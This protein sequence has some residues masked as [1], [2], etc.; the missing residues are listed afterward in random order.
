MGFFAKLAAKPRSMKTLRLLTALALVLVATTSNRAL[1]Q[2]TETLDLIT[3]LGASE[4][5]EASILLSGNLSS[6]SV[7]LNYTG[8][9]TSWPADMMVYIFAPDGSCVVWGGYNVD[10]VGGCTDLGTGF[11]NSLWPDDWDSTP[12]GNYT[13]TLDVSA[14]AL[15]G[16]GDW[17]VEVQNAWAA[18]NTVTY[19]LEFTFDGP[20]AG[21][22]PDPLACNYVPEDQQTNPLLDVCLYAEDLFGDGYD[23]DGVCLN[24]EDGD[25]I[26]D[27]DDDCF[28]VYDEC[29]N[30]AGTSTSGCMDE[31]SCNYDPDASC[32]DGG[33]L[34]LDACGDCGG[35]GVIGCIDNTACNFD[36]NATCD[37]GGCL[38]FDEC[39]VCGGSGYFGCTDDTA[40]NYD[41]GAGC[42]DG[43]CLYS[44]ALGVCG[45]SCAADE[46]GDGL[47][48]ACF[49]PETFWL[50]VETVMEHV[51]GELDGM[52]TY[53]VNL[54]C[55]TISD[56]LYSV[57]GS[58]LSPL[59]L[60]STSGTWWNHPS[61]PSWN[62]SGLDLALLDEEPLLIYD[63]YLT[64]G[65]EHSEQGPFPGA[66]WS[67]GD[68]RP[69]FE[70]GEGNNVLV[71][72]GSGG[73]HY[74]IYP[75]IGQLNTHPGFAGDDF[76]ILV[77]QMTT[78]GDIH[79]QMNVQ[80]Y[81]SG[82]ASSAVTLLLEYDSES[83]CYDL[84]PCVGEYDECGV[85]AGPGAVYE[86]GCSGP[87]EGYCDCEG[88][89]ADA[90]GVCGGTCEADVD[91]DGVCDT[92]EIPGCDDAEACNYDEGATDNDGSCE[93]AAQYYDCAGVCLEDTDM[94]GVC[95]ELE[96]AGCLDEMACNYNPMATDDSGMCTYP[97]EYLDCNGD[98]M[99][100]VNENDIC[101]ELEA[102]GCTD[103]LACNYDSEA[104]FD[105][106]SCEYAAEYYNCEGECLNDTDG[107]GV[108]DEL[109][110]VGCMQLEAC[111]WNEDA[112]EPD[113]SCAFPGDSCDD[114]DD[115]TI[116]DVLTA[117][118]DCVGEV[119][120]VDEFAQWGIA[121]FPTPVQDVMHLQFRGDAQ[122]VSTL[123][124][125]NAAGQTIRTDQIQGDATVDVSA[126]ADGVYFVSVEGTW[127]VA[128]RRIVLAGGR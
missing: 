94:D 1:A 38:T 72:S 124:L 6:V 17:I 29:G 75:G 109:E 117:D 42:D 50:E 83:I 30:C 46:D 33:C 15:S 116:N 23:C 68:P 88:N 37:S 80:V 9:G 105:D 45:G 48:D 84:D 112:T 98:C 2:C 128:T 3:T 92:E 121:L 12:N 63:S 59:I 20:C 22:C 127:G 26:C 86:C 125:Q 87:E 10:P 99:N 41:E 89:V 123:I 49:E 19:D 96:I 126:L 61:N 118:C 93:Y 91:M 113:D 40:C 77:M 82:E 52:T 51:G 53:R 85:C 43:S 122:G 102:F 27:E 108:C 69:E 103:E 11:A 36:P 100:D 101:D 97:E 65:A 73:L 35:N 64:I 62:P 5:D 56:Y 119:D 8:G 4:T 24:D 115:A 114:G 25:G 16:T 110:I 76:R 34:Y 90:I 67:T 95:D 13:A 107:D 14:G 81:P 66:V 79:G 57:S 104:G 18:G 32:D 60:N 106:G 55:S 44:D 120:R 111:N 54:V 71:N 78:M 39:G 7:T 74:L 70:P 58:A 31:M 28:G 47:C 21:E